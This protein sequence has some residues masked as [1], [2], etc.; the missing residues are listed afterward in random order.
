VLPMLTILMTTG[1]Y[2][3]P[4]A[5][6]V[7][8]V[9]VTNTT[10]IGAYRGAGRPE[11]TA[12]LERAIDLFAA[13]IG[14][15]PADVRRKNLL[16]PF[17][18]PHRTAFGALYDSGDYAAALDK[19]LNAAG[20][21][22]L[23]KEQAQRR[24]S[25]DVR[26]LGIGVASY[27]EITGMG[28]GEGTPPQENATVEVHPDGTATI[29]TGTSPHGQGHATARAMIPTHNPPIPPQQTPPTTHH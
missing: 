21:A 7:A 29:L 5:E 15:D 4:N 20:Y 16:A 22:D 10:P 27:V 9:V 17:T 12:A 23:R 24:A 28:D 8:K 3:I 19:A 6:A 2:D 25:G 13:E 26:Q 1:P 14:A 18:E 11:A